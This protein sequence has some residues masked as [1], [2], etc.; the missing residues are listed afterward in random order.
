[1]FKAIEKTLTTFEATPF[2]D[3][4]KNRLETVWRNQEARVKPIWEA[5][6]PPPKYVPVGDQVPKP[7]N[8]EDVQIEQITSGPF[9]FDSPTWTAKY[10]TDSRL[11]RVQLRDPILRMQ[12]L[13]QMFIILEYYIYLKCADDETETWRSRCTRFRQRVLTAIRSTPPHG[14]KHALFCEELVRREKFWLKWKKDGCPSFE[15]FPEAQKPKVKRKRSPW[16]VPNLALIRK[17][18]EQREA[19]REPNLLEEAPDIHALVQVLAD[20]CSTLYEQVPS[21]ESHLAAWTEADDP[22]NGIEEEYHPKKNQM[23]RFQAIR[24]VAQHHSAWLEDMPLGQIEPAVARLTASSSSNNKIEEDTMVDDKNKAENNDISAKT[25]HTATKK[26]DDEYLAAL[27]IVPPQGF[28]YIDLQK[29]IERKHSSQGEN[30]SF[31]KSTENTSKPNSNSQHGGPAAARRLRSDSEHSPIQE[32]S[33]KRLRSDPIERSKDPPRSRQSVKDEP[34]PKIRDTKTS[35]GRGVSRAAE[36][37]MR[38]DERDRDRDRLGKIGSDRDQPPP[39]PRSSAR[40]AAY[41]SDI[42]RNTSH[43][44]LSR[45]LAPPNNDRDRRPPPID[46]RRGPPPL[47]RNDR[48]GGNDHRGG[49]YDNKR[50]S[51]PR[52]DPHRR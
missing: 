13:T 32:P 42:D 2:N 25:S 12:I 43:T 41:K 40:R 37:N 31:V 15:R 21:L 9:A 10:L 50:S 49:R 17:L 36:S 11:L 51:G 28:K 4:D 44:Q 34:P 45:S 48:K 47:D 19:K 46:D 6:N 16:E 27:G 52:H 30:T 1:M 33:R 7:V 3:A 14:K 22:E 39:M 20:Q 38:A 18:D 24:L 5:S 8:M 26:T 29:Q 23:W 35:G